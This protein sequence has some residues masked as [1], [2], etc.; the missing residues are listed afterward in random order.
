MQVRGVK[1]LSLS[2][3]ANL[4]NNIQITVSPGLVSIALR[5]YFYNILSLTDRLTTWKNNL[6][7]DPNPNN[8]VASTTFYFEATKDTLCLVHN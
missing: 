5:M 4:F 2:E 1:P 8:L 6:L 3:M 7:Q